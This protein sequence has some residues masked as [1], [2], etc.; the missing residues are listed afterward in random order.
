LCASVIWLPVAVAMGVAYGQC[1]CT[2]CVPPCDGPCAC[3][4]GCRPCLQRSKLPPPPPPVPCTC[5]D[6]LVLAV[7]TGCAVVFHTTDFVRAH[8]SKRGDVV[9]RLPLPPRSYPRPLAQPL[10]P[11]LRVRVLAHARHSV[12]GQLPGVSACA[13]CHPVRVWGR[14]SVGVECNHSAAVTLH[15]HALPP[16]PPL[17]GQEARLQHVPALRVHVPAPTVPRPVASGHRRAA[18]PGHGGVRSG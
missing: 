5:C 7:F 3:M 17:P 16:P 4:C 12:P 2:C 13:R 14:A 11:V 15:L 1:C 18:T 10:G 8:R 9:S 6:T